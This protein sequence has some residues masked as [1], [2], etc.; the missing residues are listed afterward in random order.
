MKPSTLRKALQDLPRTLDDTYDRILLRIPIE[1]HYEAQIVFSLLAFSTRPIS[2]GEAAE[3][4]AINLDDGVFDPRDRLCSPSSILDICSSLVTV[5][6]FVPEQRH[7]GILKDAGVDSNKELQFSHY[8]VKE[9]LLSDRLAGTPS[10]IFHLSKDSAHQL[11]VVNRRGDTRA[12]SN[13]FSI[14][15]LFRIRLSKLVQ[16]FKKSSVR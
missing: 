13:G 5:S 12:E 14:T 7:W 2:L 6:R 1:H 3:A 16:T 9:Y 8:S 15:S 11:L 10:K 4:V